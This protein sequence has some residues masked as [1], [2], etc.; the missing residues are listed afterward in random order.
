MCIWKEKL[1]LI[2][3]LQI[4]LIGVGC[5]F[6][7]F[8]IISRVRGEGWSKHFVIDKRTVFLLRYQVRVL[9]SHDLIFSFFCWISLVL[10]F[11]RLSP[12]L[13]V[14]LL[15]FPSVVCDSV[16]SPASPSG[17]LCLTLVLFHLDMN[18]KM[19]YIDCELIF[20]YVIHTRTSG[21]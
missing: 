18:L 5:T 9:A 7:N 11:F 12:V 20:A 3:V 14:I 4:H 13:P 21:L 1:I 6:L 17:V 15:V 10:I 8:I 16:V 19:F 2:A